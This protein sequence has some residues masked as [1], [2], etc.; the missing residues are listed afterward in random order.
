MN[1]TIPFINMS[2]DTLIAQ[3]GYCES[4]Y[5]TWN[6]SGYIVI[7]FILSIILFYCPKF[8]KILDTNPHRIRKYTI[9]VLAIFNTCMLLF[10]F[11]VYPLN[12]W[13]MGL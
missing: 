3:K 2:N 11:L 6:Y 7:N 8:A 9:L 4:L 5:V 1:L 10:Q 13:L 12:V